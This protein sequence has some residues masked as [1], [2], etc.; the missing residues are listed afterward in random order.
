MFMQTVTEKFCTGL[1]SLNHRHAASCQHIEAS[2]PTCAVVINQLDDLA[3][4]DECTCVSATD[5][6]KCIRLSTLIEN[7]NGS[8]CKF[9]LLKQASGAIP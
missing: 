8:K 9:I 6:D 4:V 2:A 1:K 7:L 5:D 3:S